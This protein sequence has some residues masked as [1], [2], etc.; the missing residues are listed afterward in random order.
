MDSKLFETGREWVSCLF[1]WM[2]EIEGEG[3]CGYWWAA[4][5]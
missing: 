4:E 1:I 3:V 5:S 2:Y